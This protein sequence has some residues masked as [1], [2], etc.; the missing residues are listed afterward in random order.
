MNITDNS[1]S[2]TQKRLTK[3]YINEIFSCLSPKNKSKITLFE[4]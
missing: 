3:M 2:K 4:N 1:L